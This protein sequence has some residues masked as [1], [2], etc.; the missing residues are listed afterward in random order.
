MPSDPSPNSD[1]PSSINRA[2]RAL[3]PDD[4]ITLNEEIAGMAR[5]GLPMDQG[6]A[7]LA[8][9]M[10]SGR[11]QRATAEIAAD[12]KAGRTLPEALDRQAGRVPDFYGSLVA[13]GVRSGRVDEVL[14]TL[15]VYARAIA[16]LRATVGGAVFYPA[17]VLA[18]SFVLFGFVC[19]FII[20]QFAQLFQGFGLQLPAVTR[21]AIEIGRHPLGFLLIPPGTIVLGL[22]LAKLSLMTSDGGRRA[23]ARFIYSMPIVGTLIRSARLAA[24]AELL[25]ILV[26]H[27][28]PL[29]EAFR[30]AGE[31]SSEPVM[32]DAAR[33][34]ENDLSEGTPLGEAL[35][36][37]RLVPELIAWMTGLGERRGTLGPSLHQ[38]AEVYRRQAEMRAH[39]LRNVLPTFLILS[40][41]VL[42]GGFFMLAMFMPLIELINA[43]AK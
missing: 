1:R 10:R 5:A 43:L 31:A 34:V 29:P 28:V 3:S 20:P 2:A 9:E 17:V 33:Q 6:L 25:A 37:R 14:V 15:T 32:A 12:L 8:R 40:T 7:A 18:F 16:D 42:L 38:V 30:L 24:F 13:T 27:A 36:N 21:L 39:L 19:Y 22:V 35:R 26:D 41:G 23:W 4:L 11:L